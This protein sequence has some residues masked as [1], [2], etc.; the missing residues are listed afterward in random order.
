MTNTL[1]LSPS[2][3]ELMAAEIRVSPKHLEEI[4]ELLATAPFPINPELDHTASAL[5]Q[6]RFPIYDSQLDALREILS[7]AGFAQSLLEI[8]S[9]A[10]ELNY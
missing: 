8:H 6:V 4:L 9:M 3:G 2:S 10:A 7:T 1:L 5:T